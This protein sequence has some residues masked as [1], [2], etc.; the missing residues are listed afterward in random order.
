VTQQR[1]ITERDAAGFPVGDLSPQ[2]RRIR[3]EEEK[4]T[5][6]RAAMTA[7]RMQRRLEEIRQNAL[8]RMEREQRARRDLEE[9]QGD[10]LTRLMRQWHELDP[11]LG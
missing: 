1:R 11:T 3:K 4:N 7:R 10:S 9:H 2:L 8:H 6:A 5:Q